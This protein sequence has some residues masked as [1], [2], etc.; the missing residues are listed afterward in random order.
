MQQRQRL[1]NGLWVT[2]THDPQASRAAAL[3]HLAAGSHHEPEQWPGLAHLHEHVV[4]AGS[5]H[6]QGDQRLMGWAQAEG[7]RLNATTLPTA[8]AWFF[9]IPAAKLEDGFARM[10]DMLAQPLLSRE[11]VAQEIT[12]IDAEYRMLT[13]DAETLCEAALGAAFDSPAALARFHVGTLAHFGDDI[14]ALQQALRDYQQRFFH[15]G[16]L[17][18]QLLGPQPIE[19]LATLAERYAGILP[20]ANGAAVPKTEPLRINAAQTFALRNEGAPRLHLSFGLENIHRANASSLTLLRQLATDEAEHS[21][22]AALREQGCC[23]NAQLLLPYSSDN[24]SI[25][26]FEF[27][28]TGTLRPAATQTETIFAHWLG[29]LSSL[30]PPQLQHYAGLATQEFARLTPVDK[31]RT[32]AFGFPPVDAANTALVSD[33]QQL[34]NQLVAS[35]MTRLWVTPDITAENRHIQGFSLPLAT[36]PDWSTEISA[37][38]TLAFYPLGDRRSAPVLPAE[39]VRLAHHQ[40]D[41]ENGVLI[42]SPA[43]GEA[44]PLRWAN[45]LQASL[46]AIAAGCAHAG[47]NLSFERHQGQWLLL[48]SGD[49]G[50]MVNTLDNLLTRLSAL[51]ATLRAQGERQAVQARQALQTDIAIR[52]LLNQLPRLL[53]GELPE[54]DFEAN[55]GAENES[56]RDDDNGVETL[57]RLSWNAV[58]YGGD[59][60]LQTALSYLLSH[61]PGE[62]NARHFAVTAPQPARPEYR[63]PTQGEDAAV[64]LFCPLVESTASCLAAWQIMASLFEP[65]FFQRLRVEKNIGYVVTCRFMQTAGESGILFAVQSPSHTREQIMTE[66]RQFIEEM[67]TNIAH[68]ADDVLVEKTTAL[69]VNLQNTPQD[70]Q[71]QARDRWLA[72]HTFSPALTPETVPRLTRLQLQH[73]HRQL[74]EQQA[75]WWRLTNTP[76]SL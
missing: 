30:S 66:I 39:S 14:D 15:T 59:A 22:L 29:T 10:V 6:Y 62:I 54:A 16:N 28:L 51:P 49:N 8:T 34:L 60:E 69:I 45:I 57:P 63:F 75:R 41:N 21:L 5:Q 72:Q 37:P 55:K 33:W 70:K 50:L 1:A 27:M 35:N 31:L 19:E 20:A 65:L 76:H 61:F 38:P 3:F 46:R 68:I 52:C 25:V 42:L 48:L 23:D 64:L 67:A 32:T 4:F 13:T 74:C 12:V 2:L 71:Q 36:I 17:S 9:D 58:L 43:Q 47:G 11:A 44:L 56:E 53:S 24:G 18:L 73:F 26:T 40:S 7:A